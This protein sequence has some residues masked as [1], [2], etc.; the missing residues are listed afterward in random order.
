MPAKLLLD[1]PEK[2]CPLK[3][4]TGL[5]FILFRV[6]THDFTAFNTMNYVGPSSVSVLYQYDK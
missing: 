3:L 6:H 1:F 2:F 4:V 5:L